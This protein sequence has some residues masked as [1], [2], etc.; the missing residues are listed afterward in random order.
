MI[1]DYLIIIL[2]PQ[3]LS[4]LFYSSCFAFVGFCSK[5]KFQYVWE[6]YH[7]IKHFGAVLWKIFIFVIC[8]LIRHGLCTH[9]HTY[10]HTKTGHVIMV[11]V[12]I[13]AIWSWVIKMRWA[14]SRIK[15]YTDETKYY[16]HLPNMPLVQNSSDPV[17][18]GFYRTSE[19]ALCFQSL[20]H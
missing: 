20:R 2:S 15:A 7:L 4:C 17:R 11:F 1:L 9:M 12:W 8:K 3:V 6:F 5:C 10:K 16:D 13:S 18:H 19:G 14:D